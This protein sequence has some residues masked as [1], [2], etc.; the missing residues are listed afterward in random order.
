MSVMVTPDLFIDEFTN[1]V[2]AV[3]SPVVPAVDAIIEPPIIPPP[4]VMEEPAIFPSI[5]P[6][7]ASFAIAVTMPEELGIT[8]VF[9]YCDI[10]AM[11]IP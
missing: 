11:A 10:A 5:T 1:V 7:E 2:I 4:I 8:M 9:A 3:P 6:S